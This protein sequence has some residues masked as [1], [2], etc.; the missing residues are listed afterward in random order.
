[1]A[2]AHYK[3]TTVDVGG[4][5]KQGDGGTFQASELYKVLAEKKIEIPEPSFLPNTHDKAPYVFV[6]D[7]AYPLL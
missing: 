3:F 5:G 1:M 7:K 6:G 2:D 4:Y